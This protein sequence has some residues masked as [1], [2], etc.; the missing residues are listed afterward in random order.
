LDVRAVRSYL[1]DPNLQQGWTKK[2][3]KKLINVV[4]ELRKYAKEEFIEEKVDTDIRRI[5]NRCNALFKK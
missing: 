2:S 1:D 5:E 3:V 4:W